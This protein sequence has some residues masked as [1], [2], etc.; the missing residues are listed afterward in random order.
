MATGVSNFTVDNS[1]ISNAAGDAVVLSMVDAAT[2]DRLILSSTGGRGLLLEDASSDVLNVTVTSATDDGVEVSS[3]GADRTVAFTNLVVE[4]A[5]LEG[6]DINLDGAGNLDVSLSGQNMLTAAGNALDASLGGASTGDLVLAL[7]N[8][9]LASTGGAGV[10]IDGTGGTGT[11]FIQS[12]AD[13][14]ITEA[15]ANGFLLDTATFDADPTTAAIDQVRGMTLMIGADNEDITGDGLRLI[16]P[17]GDLAFTT[18]TIFN[19][20]GT[21]LFVDT[22]GGGT[23]FNLET[24]SG[25]SISTT[26]GDAMFLDPLTIDLVF[27]SVDSEDSPA[28]GI[29]LDTVSGSLQIGATSL[30]DSAFTSIVIQN[31]PAP[32]LAD[33]GDTTIE[34][35]IGP[36]LS[37]NVDTSVGNGTNLT[38]RFDS[39]T[40]T[41]P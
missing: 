4:D 40:I 9:T 14:V 35:L 16:D 31:T 32:L 33:F 20:G 3:L 41:G 6:L 37:D 28:S 29:F 18:L 38:I 21:G 30:V 36:T 27:D 1:V 10:N 17:T 2:L 8:T 15:A 23:T 25:S 34:S 7:D 19:D 24:G 22:K 5:S 26:D 12:L 11:L 13:N 39:L